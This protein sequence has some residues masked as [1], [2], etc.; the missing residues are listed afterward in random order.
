[1]V[2]ASFTY[3]LL[4]VGGGIAG[5][6]LARAMAQDGA[7]VLIVEREL[8]FR[9]R[10]RGEVL[11]PW[12]SVEAKALGIYEP[13]LA[14][15]GREALQEIFF[16]AGEASPP[17]DYLSSTPQQTCTMS[18][19]H[20]DMQEAL[21]I[22]AGKAGVEV[23]RGAVLRELHQDRVPEAEIVHEGAT[24]RVRARLIVG[25]DGRESTVAARLGFE[26]DKTPQELFT[27]GLQLA[28]EP[29][30]EPALH[31]FLHGIS[32]RGAILIQTKPSNYRAYLL[33]HKDAIPRRLSGERDYATALAHFGEIGVPAHWLDHLTPHGIL[34]TF[35]GSFRWITHPARGG[36]VLVGDAAATT[37][38][39]WGN[40][41]SRT[42][43]DVRLLRDR[44]L[45]DQNWSAAADAYAVD[46]D[47]YYHRLRRAEQLNTTLSFTMGEA[48]EAR[49]RRASDLMAKDR[50]FYPDV[51]GLGPEA[52]CSDR[53]VDTLLNL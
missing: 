39:V 38:P 10:I 19:F 34:A 30:M 24:R 28:G 53:V 8:A 32:G 5:S 14:T 31:F 25:A 46:H 16:A 26:R 50:D 1:M 42:L 27:T 33:H 51:S 29:P 11:L 7:H 45:N 2:G 36:C 9:D 44:L 52:R 40:G 48:A 22:G 13:L 17:R 12:G 37:D 18:F 6:T 23:W 41:L 15:C 35:D 21:S 43:R 3:D 4:I 49:R 47:D 20:P